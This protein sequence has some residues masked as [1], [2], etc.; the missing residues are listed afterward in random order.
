MSRV[1]NLT[2][3]EAEARKQADALGVGV[4]A[5]EKLPAGGIRLVCM[6]MD[7]AD[8]LRAKLKKKLIAGD[9]VRVRTRLAH[10]SR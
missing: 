5:I 4:S 10:G 7:G 1:L 8:T 3:T 6:S 9:P 2:V